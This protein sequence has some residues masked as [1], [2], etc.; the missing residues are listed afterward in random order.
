VG[1]SYYQRTGEAA[2][3]AKTSGVKKSEGR[4]RNTAGDEFWRPDHRAIVSRR[5]IISLC[6]DAR[7]RWRNNG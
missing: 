4:K 2:V 7:L 6:G 1:T 3:C 5:N